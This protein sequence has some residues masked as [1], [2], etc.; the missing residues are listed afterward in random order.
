MGG[1]ICILC[2][3]CYCKKVDFAMIG[4]FIALVVIISL[5]VFFAL[6]G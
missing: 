1:V 3:V 5:A 4:A 6:Q 2:R